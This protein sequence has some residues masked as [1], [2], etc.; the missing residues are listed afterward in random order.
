MHRLK[1]RRIQNNFK[2][3]VP[4]P[5]DQIITDPDHCNLPTACAMYSSVFRNPKI[6]EIWTTPVQQ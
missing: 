1:I 6:F 3:I 4:D 5:G 2:N